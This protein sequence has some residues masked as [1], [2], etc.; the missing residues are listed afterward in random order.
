MGV[1]EGEEGGRLEEL[2]EE[3]GQS[4]KKALAGAED[5]GLIWGHML[6]LGKL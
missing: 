5:K 3:G 1:C 4:S 6:S 2:G